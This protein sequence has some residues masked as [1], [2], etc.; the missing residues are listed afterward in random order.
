MKLD[1]E[2]QRK[3]LLE[4]LSTVRVS[5]TLGE[6]RGQLNEYHRIIKPIIEAELEPPPPKEKMVVPIDFLAP[7]TPNR[8]RRYEGMPEQ[9]GGE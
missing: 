1:S 8:I 2:G 4:M 5:V 7:D 6:L 9:N 3:D